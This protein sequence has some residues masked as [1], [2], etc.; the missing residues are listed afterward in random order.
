MSL[1]QN[2][3]ILRSRLKKFDYQSECHCSKTSVTSWKN[4]ATF[5][6]Q[7]ECHCSKTEHYHVDVL[8]LFDYQS[9]CHCSKTADREEADP[10]SFDYQS[11]CHCSKTQN[12]LASTANSLTTSQNVTAP[13]HWGAR[14]G[15][16]LRLTTSQNVTAPKPLKQILFCGRGVLSDQFVASYSIKC[17]S[18]T[19]FLSN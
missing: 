11:E 16:N 5:D 14:R 2:P 4:P 15:E 17:W 6:Y 9:E 1:L 12:Y 13:K 3:Y 19:T 18:T 8:Q 10:R 7:S